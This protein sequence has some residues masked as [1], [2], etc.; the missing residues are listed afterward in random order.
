VSEKRLFTLKEANALVPRVNDLL[1]R[2]QAST[3][4]LTTLQAR[5]EEFRAR[6]REGDHAI[7]GEAKIAQESLAEATRIATEMRGSLTELQEIGCEVKDVR[8]GLVDF[9]SLREDRTV[10]LCWR[11]GEDEIRY[12]H[13]LDTGFA[14]RQ[15]L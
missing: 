5:V 13:E 4:T 6:K 7:P 10:Y 1:Q 15:A 9:P 3:E 12:W 11:I 2:L 14:G 8:T